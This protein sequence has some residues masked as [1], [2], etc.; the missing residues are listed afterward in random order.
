MQFRSLSE[1]Y[2]QVQQHI[3]SQQT[4]RKPSCS[5]HTTA[6]VLKKTQEHEC[7]HCKVW[8][9]FRIS[10]FIWPPPPPALL[11][12]GSAGSKNVVKVPLCPQKE[13]E[14]S[15]PI[16]NRNIQSELLR[17]GE[18]LISLAANED[19]PAWAPYWDCSSWGWG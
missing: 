14:L 3:F 19:Y 5:G 15:P 6:T 8:A 12:R 18:L 4:P 13:E 10:D 2:F 17:K 11:P 9:G 16:F 1:K 7:T